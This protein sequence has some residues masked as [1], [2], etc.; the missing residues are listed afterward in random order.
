ML[1]AANRV[2]AGEVAAASE[3]LKP[4][5]AW[6]MRCSPVS[7]RLN[8][9]ANDDEQCSAPSTYLAALRS[10]RKRGKAHL[11]PSA[12]T[13]SSEPSRSPWLS[14]QLSCKEQTTQSSRR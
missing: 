5:D 7:T 10:L 1:A 8:H 11:R 6:L 4:C 14:S 3:L 13:L 12:R 9:V 2:N